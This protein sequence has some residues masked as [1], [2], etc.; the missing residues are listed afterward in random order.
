MVICYPDC[1]ALS[2]GFWLLF[3]AGFVVYY[4]SQFDFLA[5]CGDS[6][7]A[8]VSM[9]KR[10]WLQF[11]YSI[12]A[13][14]LWFLGICGWFKLSSSFLMLYRVEPCFTLFVTSVCLGQLRDES[15]P[16]AAHMM[17][18]GRVACAFG[19][20]R[21]GTFFLPQVGDFGF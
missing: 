3:V 20:L 17:S 8:C 7:L 15:C 5:Y 9:S 12:C 13:R 2:F 19:V 10:T 11:G 16:V 4:D 6:I 1:V 18:S 21:R 14:Q